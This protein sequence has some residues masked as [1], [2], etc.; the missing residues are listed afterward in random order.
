M[1]VRKR[2]KEKERESKRQV[3][4]GDTPS[5]IHLREKEIDRERDCTK[6]R[7]GGREKREEERKREKL[8]G[9]RDGKRKEERELSH[10]CCVWS[11]FMVVRSN[12]RSGERESFR[13]GA[14]ESDRISCVFLREA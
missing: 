2:G 3:H 12:S 1:G 8:K 13:N 7:E 5:I 4:H 14:L 11:S 9:P 6:E 10:E